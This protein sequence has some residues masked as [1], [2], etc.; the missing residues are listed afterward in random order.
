MQVKSIALMAFAI[1]ITGMVMIF[2][3]IHAMKSDI[4]S[5]ADYF[6]HQEKIQAD[7][8]AS[9]QNSFKHYTAPLHHYGF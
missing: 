8:Q 1:A 3:E 9:N 6:K 5:I 7:I 2:A 4:Q